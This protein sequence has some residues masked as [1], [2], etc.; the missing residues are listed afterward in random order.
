MEGQGEKYGK[1]WKFEM[2]WCEVVVWI[3]ECC[4][5]DD[6]AN[7]LYPCEVRSVIAD[8]LVVHYSSE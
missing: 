4:T 7:L 8:M 5:E 2:G 6:E 1:V 3:D